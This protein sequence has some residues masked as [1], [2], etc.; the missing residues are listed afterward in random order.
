MLSKE[1][2]GT[3]PELKTEWNFAKHFKNAERKD[4][5]N[6]EDAAKFMKTHLD[7]QIYTEL[8]GDTTTTLYMD[9]GFHSVNRTGYYSAVKDPR[10]NVMT[11]TG[12]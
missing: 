4:F 1:I 6:L 10:Y 5:D 11:Y 9:R 8:H 7:W 3:Y 12:L 2:K